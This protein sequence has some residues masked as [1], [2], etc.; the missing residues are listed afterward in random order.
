M[1]VEIY[2]CCI[3]F[4]HDCYV[5]GGE[6]IRGE[7]SMNVLFTAPDQNA[8][9]KDGVRAAERINFSDLY[10]DENALLCCVKIYRKY[11]GPISEDGSSHEITCFPTFEW[12]YDWPG[13]LQEHV[14][15][16]IR[17]NN[18]RS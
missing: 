8:A 4:V 16:K 10:P 7:D 5:R 3:Y 9:I 17:E 12:K 6:K 2:E 11:I 18:A 13:S 1:I 14:K 15:M